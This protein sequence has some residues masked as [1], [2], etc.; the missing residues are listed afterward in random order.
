MQNEINITFWTECR[1]TPPLKLYLP[2][3]I[4]RKPLRRSMN[5]QWDSNDP[6][7]LQLLYYTV[8]FGGV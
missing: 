5:F 7:Q 6:K 4:G 8:S 2:L 1:V 3:F